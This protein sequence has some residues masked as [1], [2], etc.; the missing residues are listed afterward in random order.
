MSSALWPELPAFLLRAWLAGIGLALVAGPLGCFVVWRRMAYFGDTL[1]HAALL[2]VVMGVAFDL[3]PLIGVTAA[4]VA[5]AIL[6]TLLQQQRRLAGDTLLGILAHSSLALGL[7]ALGF[8]EEVRI[9]LLGYLFGDVLAVSVR[10]LAFIWGGGIL[11]LALLALVWERLLLVTLHDELAFAEGAPVL[12]LRLFLVMLMAFAV[13]MAM[14]I[15]GILLIT[16]M[17]VIP[18]ATARTLSPTPERMALLAALFGATAVTLGLFASF[19]ADTAAGPTIVV[20]A[21]VLFLA[22]Q[23]RE[24]LC[25]RRR[26]R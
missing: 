2:G 14:K 10:D 8:M 1:A 11:L 5:V 24:W 9:D 12:A 20:T 23:T 3:D 19:R 26:W 7:V 15:V 16:A 17:L 18:A 25:S 6:L 22:V 4:G 21:L 13:A